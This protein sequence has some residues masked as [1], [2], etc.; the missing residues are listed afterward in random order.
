[1]SQPCI[2]SP[3]LYDQDKYTQNQHPKY[4][5]NRYIFDY[6]DGTLYEHLIGVGSR[7]PT[8]ET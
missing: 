7:L 6:E 2:W 5:Y 8:T 1:M 4:L 3:K